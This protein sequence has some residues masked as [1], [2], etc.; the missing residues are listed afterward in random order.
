MVRHLALA[1]SNLSATADER[2][3]RIRV[4]IQTE[5]GDIEVEL[6]AGRTPVTV[7]HFV[8]YRDVR[9]AVGALSTGR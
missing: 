7:A 1:I 5:K 8:R 9:S 2:A 6:D 3:K 4:S